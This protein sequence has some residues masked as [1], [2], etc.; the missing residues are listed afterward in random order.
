MG[1]PQGDIVSMILAEDGEAANAFQKGLT[2]E[3]ERANRLW[4]CRGMKKGCM[5]GRQKGGW[6]AAH[7]GAR[8]RVGVAQ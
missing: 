7:K 8:T 1:E 4:A 2:R 3:K 5:L 6:W